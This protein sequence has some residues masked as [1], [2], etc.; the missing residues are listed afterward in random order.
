MGLGLPAPRRAG[1]LG[2]AV[3]DRSGVDVDVLGRPGTSPGRGGR[4]APVAIGPTARRRGP[5]RRGRRGRLSFAMM[6]AA[7]FDLDKTIIARSS[8]LVFGKPFYKEGLISRSHIVK[9]IYAQ[10]VYQLVG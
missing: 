9:G 2:D 7:F 6:E 10:L 4:I 1:D 3:R 5:G 8:A